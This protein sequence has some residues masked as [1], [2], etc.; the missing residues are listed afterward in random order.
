MDVFVSV[1][2]G[3]SPS[4]EAFVSAVEARLRAE[5][6]I[7]HT[8]NRNDW[9]TLAPL[10][11]IIELM[12]RCRGAVILGV[13]RYRF[14]SGTERRGAPEEKK[15]GPRS[16]ATSWNHIEAAVAYLR[17]L[18]LFVIADEAVKLDG[19]LEPGNDWFVATMKIRPD[20]LHSEE[21]AGLLR[22]WC[23]RVRAGAASAPASAELGEVSKLSLK[24]FAGRLRV[25]ETWT[26]VTIA[27]GVFAAAVTGAFSL[28]V[29]LAP[30]FDKPAAAAPPAKPAP[31]PAP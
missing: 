18:P 9:S 12:G 29:K 25:G 23:G 2:T 11:A 26:A 31:A 6:F 7:P 28:G 17:G 16:F 27:A 10:K 22:D 8:L 24:E 20:A 13:E 4:Q 3:L 15:L 19:L 5:G 1:G 14:P 30:L 21:F